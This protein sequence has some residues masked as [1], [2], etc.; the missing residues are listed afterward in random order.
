[1]A[2]AEVVTFPARVAARAVEVD[3]VKVLLSLLV[4][5]FY[6]VGAVA[7][8]VWLLV[9]WCYAAVLVGFADVTKRGGAD[10]G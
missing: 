1:M 5:P 4:L 6:V 3:V 8:V 7:A 9:R 10:V 2:V